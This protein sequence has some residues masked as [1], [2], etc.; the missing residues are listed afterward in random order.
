MLVDA[1]EKLR[2]PWGDEEN[3]QHGD[4]LMAFDT[5]SAKMAS[6][7]L[8]TADFLKYL[9]AIKSLWADSGIQDAY[10]RRREF[11]LVGGYTHAHTHSRT[12]TH[13]KISAEGSLWPSFVCSQLIRT[14]LC[15]V[16]EHI[17][18]SPKP[19][20]RE[21]TGVRVGLFCKLRRMRIE[22]ET[23]FSS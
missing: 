16:L 9:P 15:V 18:P 2:I 4:N 22:S 1:R 17:P 7:Q 21:C 8:D 13:F 14:F 5:R 11:Q 19:K 12:H 3:Q 10:D 20:K 6:G 23:A